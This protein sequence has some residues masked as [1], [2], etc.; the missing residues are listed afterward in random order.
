MAHGIPRDAHPADD[1]VQQAFIDIW[2]HIRRL[3]DPS[4]FDGWSYRLLVNACHDEA[5]RKPRWLPEGDIS[6]FEAPRVGDASG[7]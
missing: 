7:G 1:A 3:R 6:T 2:R 5:K 4:K